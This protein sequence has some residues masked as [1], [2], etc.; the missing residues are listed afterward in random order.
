MEYIVREAVLTDA[1]ALAELN[2]N[3][4]GY[5]YSTKETAVNLNAA[6]SRKGEKIYVAVCGERVVGYIHACDYLLLFSPPMKNILGIAVDSEYTRNGIGSALIGA[7]ERWAIETN[8]VGV[9]LVSGESRV[10]AHRFYEKCGY[11]SNKMQ[12]NF[13]KMF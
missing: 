7:V 3:E 4:M 6:L 5:D 1:E 8:A 10:G 13:K 9:R 12:K 2:K 11:K